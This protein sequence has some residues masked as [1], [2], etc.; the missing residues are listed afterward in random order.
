MNPGLFIVGTPIGN[1]EDISKRTLD[2]LR[3]VNLI[4]AEDTRHTRK[5]LNRYQIHG[6]LISC[7]KFNENSR[8]QLALNKIKAGNSVALVTNAGMPCISDPGARMITACRKQGIFI[9]VIP[10]PS[11][12]TTAI[13]LCGFGGQRFLFEGFL[14]H[15]AVA[16]KKRLAALRVLPYPIVLFESPYRCIKLLS[17]LKTI[18]DQR[19]ILLARELTKINEECLWGTASEIQDLLLA[20]RKKDDKVRFIKGEIVIVIAPASKTE[21]KHIGTKPT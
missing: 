15:K 11:S 13:A 12:V 6:Q 16:R 18:F 5:L 1:L 7:H 10:G 2:V 19:E 9:S 8:V 17:D 21:L 4:L 20:R 3:S 14:S